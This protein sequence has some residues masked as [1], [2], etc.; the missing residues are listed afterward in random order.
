M[1]R[2]NYQTWNKR[3]RLQFLGWTLMVFGLGVFP[4]QVQA[5]TVSLNVLNTPNEAGDIVVVLGEDVEV[6]FTVVDPG[7]DLSKNDKIKLV[8]VDNGEKISS[9]K[10]GTS[11]TGT[12]SLKAKKNQA[13]TTLEVK[14][15]HDDVAQATAPEE[16]LVVANEGTLA[17]SEQIAILQNNLNILTTVVT[18]LNSNA[19]SGSGVDGFLPLWDGTQ[20][21][22]GSAVFQSASGNVGIGT[23]TPTVP[24]QV[25]GNAKVTGGLSVGNATVTITSDGIIFP[26][27]TLQTTAFTGGSGGGGV[28]ED[29]DPVNWTG[30]HNWKT[31]AGNG[32]GK[33]LKTFDALAPAQDSSTV[34]SLPVPN[35]SMMFIKILAIGMDPLNL[36][37]TPVGYE[38]AMVIWNVGGLIDGDTGDS[39]QEIAGIGSTDQ[40]DF[41]PNG[42][43]VDVFFENNDSSPHKLVGWVEYTSILIP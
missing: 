11:L 19:V 25:Q 23:T 37:F 43:N 34:F 1:K 21:L 9:K 20:S 12:V 33:T 10:R 5:A 30:T 36:T 13:L 22:E 42:G 16:V 7:G 3:F 31:D 6:E 41:N 39:L 32:T 26:D 38:H 35:D 27:A 24:L 17:L 28:E 29:T 4:F 15:I 18:N 2:R 40:F 8:R 14:Y